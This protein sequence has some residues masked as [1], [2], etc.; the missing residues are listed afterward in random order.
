MVSLPT[1]FLTLAKED[2]SWWERFWFRET[3][4]T[5]AGSTDAVY[6]FIFW[7]SAVFFVPI[8]AMVIGFG[9]K[10]RRSKVGEVAEASAAHNTALEL[11]W[12][13]T[14]AILMAIMFFWGFKHYMN[15]LVAPVDAKQV[16]VTAYQWGWDFTY[17]DGRG[18]THRDLDV[19]VAAGERVGIVGAVATWFSPPPTRQP[20]SQAFCMHAWY[21]PA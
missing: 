10:Y 16:Y 17:P 20:S 3:A 21:M 12:S 1:Y 8:V 6:N 4:S 7:V 14:P 19:T 5:F 15:K 9:I 13:V 2:L 11:T 18:P